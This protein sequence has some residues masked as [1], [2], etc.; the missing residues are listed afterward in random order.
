[1]FI[2]LWKMILPEAL[3]EGNIIFQSAINIDIA[4]TKVPYLFY[5]MPAAHSQT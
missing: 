4:L 3:A 2:A 5:Y 1:M